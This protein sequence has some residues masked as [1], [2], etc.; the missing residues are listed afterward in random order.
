MGCSQSGSILQE[1]DRLNSLSFDDFTVENGQ[2]K[3]N[4]ER[5]QVVLFCQ[6]NDTCCIEFG[7]MSR[8]EQFRDYTFS[9]LSALDSNRLLQLAIQLGN[10]SLP[11]KLPFIA[12][13]QNG[14]NR[15]QSDLN[16]FSSI[17]NLVKCGRD[18]VNLHLSY[19]P[20]LV[21]PPPRELVFIEQKKITESGETCPICLIDFEIDDAVVGL[22]CE[23]MFHRLCIRPWLESKPTCPICRVE[24]IQ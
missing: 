13:F 21:N 17:L 20:M 7:N 14:Y 1:R 9:I 11:R 4:R 6:E 16:H 15:L 10:E 23:H 5:V 8:N 2:I 19:A 22:D 12:L 18:V 24:L 3:V